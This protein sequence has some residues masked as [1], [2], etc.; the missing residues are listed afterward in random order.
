MNFPEHI[1]E[2]LGFNHVREAI[3]RYCNSDSGKALVSKIRF[4]SK[5]EQVIKHCRQT[6]EYVKIIFNGEKLEPAKRVDA[7]RELDKI[8]TPG[9]FL[10]PNV[11]ND[12]CIFIST[13]SQAVQFLQQRKSDF[14]LLYNLVEYIVIDITI[15]N[16]IQQ[17]INDKGEVRDNATPE[18]QKI[19]RGIRQLEGRARKVVDQVIRQA[20]KQGYSPDDAVLTIR[21]GRLVIPVKAEHKRQIKGFIQ[22]ESSTGQT[23][24]LEPAEALEINNDLKDLQYQERREIHKILVDLADLIRLHIDDLLQ[25]HKRAS[26]LDFIRAKARY[27]IHAQSVLPEIQNQKNIEWKNAR[28][29]ILED[30]LQKQGRKIVEQNIKIDSSQRMLVISGPNA[31][32]KSVCLKTIGLLQYM[33]QCGLLIPVEEGSK[34]CLFKSIFIDIGDQQSIENDLS[35]YSSHLS[36]MAHFVR[37][38]N[39]HTL[40]LIDEFGTG[41]DPQFGGAIAESILETLLSQGAYGA[42]TTHYANLK[43][44]AGEKPGLANARMRFDIARLEPLFKLEI[45]K[46][47]SSFALEIASKIGL[48]EAVLQAA[49]QHV[50]V[51]QVEMDKLLN[52]LE[53]ERKRLD[54]K[55]RS[56]REKEKA[57]DVTLKN[58]TELKADLDN[59]KKEIMNQAKSEAKSLIAKA[60]QK[61]ESAIHAIKTSKADKNVAKRERAAIRAMQDDLAP[62]E[63]IPEKKVDATIIQGPVYPGDAVRIKG[64][65][66]VGEVTAVGKNDAEVVFG[67]IKSKVKL[68]RLEK[69][70]TSKQTKTQSSGRVGFNFDINRQK[71]E[72][73]PEMDIRGMRAEEAYDKLLQFVDN[74]ILF[75][76]PQLRI[77]HGKGDGVLKHIVRNDIANLEAVQRI[78]SEHPDRGGDGVSLLYLE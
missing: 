16:K 12:L 65:E 32:G 75:S 10:E 70:K 43:K 40:L 42:V 58:Y 5:Y 20:K 26:Q 34:A 3:C 11:L 14:P 4:Q 51:D 48:P 15:A 54:E 73:S 9:T 61:I 21:N 28:H 49:R 68:N 57:I 35:T 63:V 7:V 29:P 31:G 66:S 37:F 50:G 36:N 52:E 62:E 33:L 56:I 69:L 13:A 30:S 6:D 1:E 44:M 23:V 72:F 64:Q 53:L 47:G 76:M 24:F 46:P 59:R 67:A 2:K 22:D 71:S 60:N 8:R 38:A 17:K 41:T 18:L 45:G 19:R 74:G 25:I 78:E 77:V 39:K 55:M 27:A